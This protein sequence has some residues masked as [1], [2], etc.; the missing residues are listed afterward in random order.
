MMAYYSLHIIRQ[1]IS[2][3]TS[4]KIEFMLRL[5]LNSFFY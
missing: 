5:T 1:V 2:V 4:L 3:K